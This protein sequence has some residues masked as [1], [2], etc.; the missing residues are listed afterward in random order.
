MAKRI[1]KGF[2]KYLVFLL[3]NGLGGVLAA[4]IM[5]VMI[6]DSFAWILGRPK[7]GTTYGNVVEVISWGLWGLV[8]AFVAVGG[9]SASNGL[10]AVAP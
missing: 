4:T 10:H 2:G 6:V 5:T 7:F 9:Y 1:L 3:L 8:G